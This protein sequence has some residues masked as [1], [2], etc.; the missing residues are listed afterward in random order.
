MTKHHEILPLMSKFFSYWHLGFPIALI[1]SLFVPSHFVLGQTLDLS[2]K[3]DFISSQLTMSEL[4]KLSEKVLSL[5]QANM[6]TE[7]ISLANQILSS[8][9]SNSGRCYYS[10]Y[11]LNYKSMSYKKLGNYFLS[12]ANNKLGIEY[13]KYNHR[14]YLPA[15]CNNLSTLYLDMNKAASA[16]PLLKN[17]LNPT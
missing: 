10:C 13:A 12:R 17:N 6:L 7:S 14:D 16:L 4:Y 1:I 11:I 3:E 2:K 9:I 5:K 15:L 8:G